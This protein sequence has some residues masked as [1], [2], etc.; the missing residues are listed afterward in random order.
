MALE[1]EVAWLRTELSN[2]APNY[3]RNEKWR[4]RYESGD[5]LR[6]IS[7]DF[8]VDV[9]T[10]FR[11]LKKMGVDTSNRKPR[12]RASRGLLGWVQDER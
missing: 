9:S 6:E 11:Q 10:V 7:R 2:L 12:R 5:S 1:D 8:D 3:E 4:E